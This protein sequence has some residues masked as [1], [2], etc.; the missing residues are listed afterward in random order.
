LTHATAAGTAA[1]HGR[2]GRRVEPEGRNL[3]VE[4]L[5]GE[6]LEHHLQQQQHEQQSM[7]AAKYEANPPL[8]L[9]VRSS[10]SW[11]NSSNIGTSWLSIEAT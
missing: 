4:Q 2:E 3:Q 9:T 11:V 5:V 1:L 10:S 7:T 6:L 8:V